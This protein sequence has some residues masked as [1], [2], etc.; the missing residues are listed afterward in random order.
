MREIDQRNEGAKNQNY[1]SLMAN[2]GVIPYA[3]KG[4]V[5]NKKPEDL[6]KCKLVEPDDFVINSMNYQIGSY[7]VSMYAGVCSPV[8]IVLR[9]RSEFV[10]L[11]FA[12]RIFQ[13]SQFQ[14]YAQSFGNGILDHRRSISWNTLKN[15]TV[16][17]PS[18]DEQQQ[19]ADFLDRET[20]KID[21]LIAKQEQLIAT[22]REDRTAT[23]TH[24]VT[25][26]LDTSVEL[27]PVD[28]EVPAVPAH[29]SVRKL[30]QLGRLITGGTPITSELEYYSADQETG[31][32]WYRPDDL[33]STGAPSVA[34][35]Y[36]TEAGALT[37][38]YLAA[39]SVL[40][41][42]IG[43]TLAKVGYV[44]AASSC[45]QQINAFVDAKNPKFLFYAIT[46]TY[47]RIW[48][49]SMGNTL[50]IISAGRLGAVKIAVPPTR[51]QDA[52]VAQLDGVCTKIDALTAKAEQVIEVLREY[53]SALITDAVTGK[54]D[55]R[56]AA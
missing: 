18:L 47:D 28:S 15:L 24:A 10:N 39:P 30:K 48:A 33:D 31:Y 12:L 13:T 1:L 45:N 22:L 9:H 38:P 26:G 36:L 23:I 44:T 35:R 2:I 8:Y 6:T 46:A 49:A 37:V 53:R 41:V 19:I 56:G 14:R 55:V 40:V 17:L 7:G 21:A 5:G 3:E 52:I 54:I 32:P 11:R 20:A 50:P 43:A 29:W 42:S 4:D 25:K 51:E 16:P 34:S 27:K